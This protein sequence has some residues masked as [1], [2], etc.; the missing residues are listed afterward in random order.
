M[1]EFKQKY[2]SGGGKKDGSGGKVHFTDKAIAATIEKKLAVKDKAAEDNKKKKDEVKGYIMSCIHFLVGTRG[3]SKTSPAA[4]DT[5]SA[6]ASI[7]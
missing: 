3:N 4:V 6:T 5:S 1:E 2:K 7:Q